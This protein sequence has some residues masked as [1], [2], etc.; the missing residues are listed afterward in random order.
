MGIHHLW[1]LRDCLYKV[2]SPVSCNRSAPAHP[3][4][5]P[6]SF[7]MGPLQHHLCRE[8][9]AQKGA[10]QPSRNSHLQVNSFS[11]SKAGCCPPPPW[12]ITASYL[13]LLPRNSTS[14]SHPSDKP[15]TVT[16][17]CLPFCFDRNPVPSDAIKSNFCNPLASLSILLL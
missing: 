7:P 3:G 10:K 1:T 8:A 11:L 5:S 16:T 15:P 17:A 12:M 13:Q 9:R 2:C 14:P 4:E 6:C